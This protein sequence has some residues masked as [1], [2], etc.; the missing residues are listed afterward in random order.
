MIGSRAHRDAAKV[1]EE[2]GAGHEQL[3]EDEQGP[4]VYLGRHHENPK[5][6]ALTNPTHVVIDHYE[7]E[8]DA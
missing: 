7:S 6:A 1:A 2:G 3:P 8:H 5:D 4:R